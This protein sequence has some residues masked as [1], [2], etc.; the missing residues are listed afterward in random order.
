[1]AARGQLTVAAILLAAG[2]GNRLGAGIPKAFCEVDGRTLLEHGLARFGDHPEVRDVIVVAPAAL[3]AATR[4][5]TAGIVVAGG[6]RRQDSVRAGLAA[7]ASDVDTVL[8][9]DVARPFVPAEVISRVLAALRSGADAAVP[10]IAVIDTIKT[11]SRDGVVGRTLDRAGLRA[12]QTPQ[13]FRRAALVAA[14]A[15][16]VDATNDVTDDATIDATDDAALIEQCGGT[17]VVVPGADESFKITRSWDLMM[18]RAMI[19]QLRPAH[20]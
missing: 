12:I 15:Q 11:V 13:G 9:Q 2:D 20:Q 6:A 16:T 4:R 18:A 10:A 3:M 17:V 1:M 5:L 14:H 8:V 19:D 7:V